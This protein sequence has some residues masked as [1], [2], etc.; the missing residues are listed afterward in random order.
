MRELEFQQTGVPGPPPDLTIEATVRRPLPNQQA[1]FPPLYLPTF[2][3]PATRVLPTFTLSKPGSQKTVEALLINRNK[4]N[5]FQVEQCL[6]LFLAKPNYT[7]R[8][9][10]LIQF[11]QAKIKPFKVFPS[12]L[13]G[14]H[15]CGHALT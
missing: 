14:R 8:C 7:L 4:D 6:P 10:D 2:V 1:Q 13:R 11:D 5:R 12:P 15:L 3:P 9:A